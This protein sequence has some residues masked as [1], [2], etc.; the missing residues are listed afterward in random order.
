MPFSSRS[1]FA[2]GVRSIF[3]SSW[4]NNGEFTVVEERWTDLAETL[5][6]IDFSMHVGCLPVFEIHAAGLAKNYPAPVRK[7]Y[8]HDDDIQ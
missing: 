7:K 1:F 2:E 8:L 6:R 4:L 5:P 3:V